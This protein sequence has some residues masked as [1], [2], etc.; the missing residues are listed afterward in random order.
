MAIA[1]LKSNQINPLTDFKDKIN[2]I[3]DVINAL[4][5]SG[6]LASDVSSLLQWKATGVA[7]DSF[8]GGTET[9]TITDGLITAVA[10]TE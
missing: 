7:S 9:A 6:T 10:P 2:E 8:V 5:P 4:D 3:I 1:K